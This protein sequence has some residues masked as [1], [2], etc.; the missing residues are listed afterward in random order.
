[1][2]RDGAQ[3][4]YIEVTLDDIATANRIAGEILGRTLDDLPPQTRRLLLLIDEFVSQ[5]GKRL[6][7]A[8]ADYHFTRR[9]VWAHTGLDQFPGA[10]PSG[11]AHANGIRAGPSRQTR[12]VFSVYELLYGGEGRDGKPFL[13]GLLDV[14]SLCT[15][16][17]P[18]TSQAEKFE[19]VNGK[20]EGSNPKFEGPLRGQAAPIAPP[21]ST[22]QNATFPNKGGAFGQ[23]EPPKPQKHEARPVGENRGVSQ[24]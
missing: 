22:S 24:S 17:V 14:E 16:T 1:M 5:E 6:K 20:L 23:V 21:T 4:Y 10:R 11:P 15:A 8:R 7:L 18:K 3:P 19:G 9:D 13:I 2:K 12:L